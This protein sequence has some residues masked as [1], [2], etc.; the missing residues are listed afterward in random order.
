MCTESNI[1]DPITDNMTSDVTTAAMP[2]PLKAHLYVKCNEYIPVALSNDAVHDA[3][4]NPQQGGL[5]FV[6]LK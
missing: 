6:R 3:S 4:Y 5:V 1:L 2:L